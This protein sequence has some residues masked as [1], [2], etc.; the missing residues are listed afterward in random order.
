MGMQRIRRCLNRLPRRTWFLIALFAV[1][2]FGVTTFTRLA[3]SINCIILLP[4]EI[5]AAYVLWRREGCRRDMPAVFGAL[6][7][8]WGLLACVINR[9]ILDKTAA[10]GFWGIAAAWFYILRTPRKIAPE[11]IR[12]EFCAV[13]AVYLIC[14]LP[15]LLIA[16]FSLFSGVAMYLPGDNGFPVGIVAQGNLT[17]RFR[18]M[19]N[20][21]DAATIEMMCVLFAVYLF[22]NRKQL[23]W[24]IFSV[25]A[26]LCNLMVLAH[27]QSRS[28]AISLSIGIGVLVFRAVF[29]RIPRK[30][31]RVVLGVLACA[32]AF[33]VVLKGVD[34][35]RKADIEIA[36]RT[37]IYVDE[38]TLNDASYA[39]QLGQFDVGSSG[40]TKLWKRVSEYLMDHPRALLSGITGGNVMEIVDEGTGITTGMYNPHNS[41]L[42]CITTL[43]TPFALLILAFLVYMFPKCWKVLTG[44]GRNFEYFFVALIACML[45]NSITEVNLFARYY[46]NNSL[47]MLAC[48]YVLHACARQKACV[49]SGGRIESNPQKT[50]KSVS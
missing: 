24:R 35:V 18:V 39:D 21:N 2:G 13:C 10:F 32:L 11:S 8:L 49:R 38:S 7:L 3:E 50:D 43:G 44:E 36:K 48:G 30:K 37:A 46:G 29:A 9:S 4:I 5:T 25:F 41:L 16:L 22:I 19:D 28:G 26:G 34:L 33:F 47:F 15:L 12:D 1:M 23:G 27:T 14:Y 6:I 42:E 45:A 20:A 17:G 31:W 40:R